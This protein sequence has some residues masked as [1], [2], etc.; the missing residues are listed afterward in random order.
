MCDKL[1][2]ITQ[3]AADNIAAWLQGK[4]LKFGKTEHGMN[5]VLESLFLVKVKKLH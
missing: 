2:E 1:G 5:M 4:S 3:N